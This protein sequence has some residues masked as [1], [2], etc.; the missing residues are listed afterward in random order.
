MVT[1]RDQGSAPCGSQSNQSRDCRAESAEV[2]G[3]EGR[4]RSLHVGIRDLECQSQVKGLP[5]A[6]WPAV[7][8]V[9]PREKT[10]SVD[11]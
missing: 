3:A 8:L 5:D 1:K 9:S 11:L 10:I 4:D 2:K 7:H 6:V